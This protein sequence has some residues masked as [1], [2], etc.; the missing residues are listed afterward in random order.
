MRK[1][2]PILL[3]CLPLCY[4][5]TINS[6]FSGYAAHFV[7]DATFSPFDQVYG[8]GQFITVKRGRSASSYEVTDI[9]GNKETKQ[10]TEAQSR[11]YYQYGFGG[12][13][14]GT[15]LQGGGIKVYDWACP[16]CD[17]SPTRLELSELGNAKCPDCKCEFD[18]NQNGCAIKG[19]SRPLW[20]Y[21]VSNVGSEIVIRN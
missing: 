7:F 14:I 20:Q 4:A 19:E 10:L 16:N 1:I 12:F 6:T 13:I 9:F 18:L 8:A 15:P 2:L 11:Q 5:C 21:K 3:L 17:L